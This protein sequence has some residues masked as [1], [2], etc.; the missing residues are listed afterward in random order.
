MPSAD[1]L[2]VAALVLALILWRQLQPREVREENAYRLMLIL[3]VAG[4]VELVRFAD[5]HRVTALAWA[6]VGASLAVGAA[7]GLMRGA[8]VRIWRRDGVLVR[9]GTLV[10]VALWAVGIGVHLLVDAAV[11][12]VD[13]S[14]DG[15]GS[16]AIL[17]YLGIALAAQ[18]LVTLNRAAQ[19]AA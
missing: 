8:T 1:N 17:L 11:S 16:T 5:D 18:Q 9:Q 14:A 2:L 10:T 15:I 7:F 19:L 4:V 13:S 6:L 3:G 12:G